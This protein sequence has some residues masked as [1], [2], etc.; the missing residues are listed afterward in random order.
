[1]R[2]DVVVV[3]LPEGKLAAGIRQAVEDLFV[4]AFI[5]QAAVEA[6]DVPVLLRLAQIDVRPFDAAFVGLLQDGLAGE[7]GAVVRKDASRFAIDANQGVEFPFHRGTRNAGV[8]YQD[9][10]F[11]ATTIVEG[12]DAELSAG[13]KCVG[14]DVQRPTLVRLHR[15][16]LRLRRRRTDQVAVERR[17]KEIAKTRVRYGYRRVHVLLR[18]E[19]WE[20][21]MKK[22]RRIYNELG[23][24]LRN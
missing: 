8:G 18:R 1:M 6:L 23:L 24:Q 20:I 22:T 3:V 17:I 13:A 9:A 19:G 21:N 16:S 7:R 2:S 5:S 12:Q 4:L 10:D 14:Q 15:A 11:M